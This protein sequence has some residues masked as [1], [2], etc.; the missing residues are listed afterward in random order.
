M[1]ALRRRRGA[2]TACSGTRQPWCA[3]RQPSLAAASA[4]PPPKN[5]FAAR[6]RR[7]WRC[8]AACGSSMLTQTRAVPQTAIT[9][10]PPPQAGSFAAV[11]APPPPPSAAAPGSG[12][13]PRGRQPRAMACQ[14]RASRALACSS[15]GAGA[16]QRAFIGKRGRRPPLRPQ[17][18]RRRAEA[19]R[20]TAAA[21]AWLP[22]DA[23]AGAASGL[24]RALPAVQRARSRQRSASQRRRQPLVPEMQPLSAPRRLFGA[25]LRG[26]RRSP[27]AD[28]ARGVRTE[29]VPCRLPGI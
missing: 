13:R 29:N 22:R 10:A 1:A 12:P 17:A 16:A 27:A 28:R 4:R 19:R 7:S 3:A 14:A 21:G 25:W 26:A 23:D 9:G 8:H 11:L 18:A 20:L 6:R 24:Q 2:S 15:H 5:A